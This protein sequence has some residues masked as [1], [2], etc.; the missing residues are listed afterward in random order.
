MNDIN[1]AANLWSDLNDVN[2][3]IV[4]YREN[5]RWKAPIVSLEL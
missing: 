3:Q 1:P 5:E 2:R 4:D